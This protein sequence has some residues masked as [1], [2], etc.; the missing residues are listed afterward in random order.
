M[1]KN[2]KE[3]VDEFLAGLNEPEVDPFKN[4]AGDPFKKSESIQKEE[5]EDTEE[6]ERPLPFHKDPKVQRYIEKEIAKKISTIQP[7]ETERFVRETTNDKDE[8]DEILTRIIGNDTPEKKAA[9]ADFK[10]YL[11]S[12]EEKGASRAIQQ[13]EYQQQEELQAEVEAQDELS[14]GFENV[15]ETFGVDIT[16]NTPLARKTR[17]DFIDFI[18]RVAPKNEDGEVV[19]YPDFEQT[20]QLFQENTKRPTNSRAKDLAARSMSRSSD[21]SAAPVTGK[22]WADVDKLFGKL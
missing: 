22:T 2:E 13:L 20:F 21:A 19:G 17:N 15:E 7:T 16:S 12:L 10:R 1:A 3:A 14:Q 9:V 6:E 8:A 4:E 11:A 18:K 5:V